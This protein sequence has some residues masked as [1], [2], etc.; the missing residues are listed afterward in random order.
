MGDAAKAF[1]FGRYRLV[2]DRRALFAGGQEISIRS[3]AF[4]LLL[5]LVER[6]E[7]TVP[8]DELIKLVWP[9]RL[10]EEGNLTVH[11]AALRKVLGKGVIATLPGRGYRFVAPVA[12]ATSSEMAPSGAEQKTTDLTRLGAPLAEFGTA[13]LP[14]TAP[15]PLTRLIG[16]AGDLDRAEALLGNSRLV[17]V[18]G[19]GGIGKSRLALAVA[20]RARRN[21]PDG[22]CVVDLGPVE[23]PDL[24]ATAIASALVIDVRDANVLLG[25]TIFL[26][27]RRALLVMDG[28]EH[29]VRAVAGVAEAILQSCPN[30]AILAT[31]REPLR[32]EG[33]SLHRL[34]PLKMA[35]AMADIRADQLDD[36]PA[37]ELFVERA[38]AVLGEFAPT[39][40]E[41]RDVVEICR[42]LDGI[43]LAIELAAPALQALP[44][45]ELRER[46]NSRFG[47]LMAGRRTAL[48]R[49]QTLKATIG[50]SL[51]LLDHAELHLLLR[52]S[53][54]SGGWTAKAAA[55]AAG[56]PG[57]EDETL[58][59]I[60]VLIDKSLVHADLTQAQPRYRMLDATRYYAAERLSVQELAE[61]R[62]SLTR[63]LSK[64]YARAE[65]DWP[66]MADEHWFQLYAPELENLRAGLAWAFG[67]HGDEPLG[68]E[69][70]S[71]TEHV[72]GELSLVELQH[73]FD[74]AIS[75]ITEATPPDVAG[76]LWLGRCGWLALGETEALSASRHAIAL[77]RIAGNQLNLGRALWR[78]AFQLLALGHVD[79]AE[80]YLQEARQLLRGIRESK[81]LVSWF[82]VQA[83][84]RSHQGKLDSAHDCLGKALSLA[85]RLQSRRDIA[86]TLGSIAETHFAAGRLNDAIETAREALASLEPAQDRSAWVQ[87]IAGALASY[88]LAKGDIAQARPIAAARLEAARIMGLRHE[89]VDNFER[90]GL[91]A[92]IEGDI[93][94][95]GHLLGYSQAYRSERKTLRSFSSMAVQDRLQAE[96]HKRLSAGELQRLIEEG[97]QFS[98]DE[99]VAALSRITRP[100]VLKFGQHTRA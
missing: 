16:R 86:L 96:L 35:P 34:K 25:I 40:A 84:A 3:R 60:A 36:Y 17:T 58:R 4:D 50:W 26:S 68:I 49:Q 20:D 61:A 83:L 92:A 76:R 12:E 77:F 18:V 72:W 69:L 46:L 37:S 71:Y 19:A 88:L 90:L 31:S 67:P 39:D 28:C 45:A 97:A 2:P 21:F 78:H 80:P 70:T 6:R 15:R 11:I 91:I 73:W 33:E 75:K 74:L 10:V 99:A 24:V 79:G 98:D 63:W 9:G 51:D 82:R 5:A 48:P 64:T 30:V 54:F 93:A 44:L 43:P 42:R 65:D 95:A 14:D 53:V 59:L 89:V 29:L 47:L 1:L 100:K 94:T 7:Q 81:A 23:D 22:V 57:E 38:R 55:S 32:A 27:T 56:R 85:R 52:L 62:H 41:A 8:K 87:H 13:F 66:Y